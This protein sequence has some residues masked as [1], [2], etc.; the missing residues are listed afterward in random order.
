MKSMFSI[1]CSALVALAAGCGALPPTAPLAVGAAAPMFTLQTARGGTATRETG[2]P[3]LLTF[4]STQAN[5][6]SATAD[7][8]RSQLVFVKSMLQQHG[9]QGLRAAIIEGATRDQPQRASAET[10]HNFSYDWGLDDLPLLADTPD[11][12]TARAYGVQTLPTTFLIDRAGVIVQ[13]WDGPAA[14]A[15]LGL[16]VQALF[17][18]APPSALTPTC[19]TTPAQAVFVGLGLAR[20]LSPQIWLV[21][22]GQPWDHTTARAA[23]WVVLAEGAATL[24]VTATDAHDTTH[25][26]VG[27][28]LAPL[29][30]EQARV[31]LS[32]V[33]HTAA[34]QA[35]LVNVSM[36]IP[37]T[38][39]VMLR[40]EV[41]RPGQDLPVSRGE[42]VVPVE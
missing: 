22:G 27:V 30:D 11:Q 28:A 42:M 21:D 34:M 4:I 18:T 1:A 36:Q 40:A 20:P 14:A 41:S 35:Y 8:S 2:A 38:G 3:L 26:V 24:Q 33:P 29:P 31:L 6:E 13:R 25:A 23:S 32:S 39:C 12:A 17:D 7:P 37:A 5:T 19:A 9:G 16:S 15:Q 10:L